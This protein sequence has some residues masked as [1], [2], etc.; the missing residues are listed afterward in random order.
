MNDEEKNIILIIVSFLSF[1][2]RQFL[3][4]L[5]KIMSFIQ[6]LKLHHSINNFNY[7]KKHHYY[8]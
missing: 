4:I 7:Y 1:P 2:C 5:A 6:L 3:K 8:I